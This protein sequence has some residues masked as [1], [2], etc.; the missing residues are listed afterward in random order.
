MGRCGVL[1]PAEDGLRFKPEGV[2]GDM[3]APR[4]RKAPS[5]SCLYWP[6]ILNREVRRSFST[7]NL[8]LSCVLSAAADCAKTWSAISRIDVTRGSNWLS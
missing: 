4:L 1:L 8:D 2:E 6:Q 5:S 3:E 7:A